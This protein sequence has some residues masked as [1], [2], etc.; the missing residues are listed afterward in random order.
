MT[1]YCNEH[2]CVFVCLCVRED[3]SRTT[4]AIFT[5]FCACCL[6]PWLGPPPAEWLNFKGNGQ[7]LGFSS[8]LT[9]HCILHTNLW[10]V[11]KTAKPIGM[12][13]GW[14]VGLAWGTVCYVGVTIPETRRG[15]FD[16]SMCPTSLIPLI[17]VANW[18]GLCSGIRQWLTF[19]CKRWTSLSSAAKWGCTSGFVEDI[20]FFTVGRKAVWISLRTTDFT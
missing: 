7:F 19:N 20:M 16:K 18:T 17:I 9:M 11:Q 6:W 3:I 14:W 4:R 13:F 10:P 1:K 15:N 12:P 8:P 5:Y 2:V